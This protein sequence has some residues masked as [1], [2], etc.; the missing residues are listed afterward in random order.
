MPRFIASL[1]L[2]LLAGIASAEEA[3]PKSSADIEVAIKLVDGA[4]EMF[5]EDLA[6]MEIILGAD[7]GIR[8]L[9]LELFSGDSRD[10]HR[11]YNFNNVINFSYRYL[12]ITGKGRVVIRQTAPFELQQEKF[13]VP[14][15]VA[16]IRLNDYQ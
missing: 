3:A 11:W 9:H 5:R 2:A 6:A 8:Y 4:T 16:P 14:E 13:A 15:K 10:T 7:G 12:K 1:V